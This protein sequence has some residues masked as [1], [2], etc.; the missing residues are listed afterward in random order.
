MVE[1]DG[2]A[3]Y[4]ASVAE[5]SMSALENMTDETKTLRRELTFMGNLI[6]V[7]GL[8]VIGYSLAP[9]TIRTVLHGW[10]LIVI[11]IMQLI[12]GY[13]F[14]TTGSSATIRTVLARSTDSGRY[15]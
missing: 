14:Q 4:P 5:D 15:R 8:L 2:L 3:A 1:V 13:Y 9:A 10:I 7:L 6:A 11:G 12:L